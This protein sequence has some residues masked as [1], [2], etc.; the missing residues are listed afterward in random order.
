MRGRLK[1]LGRDIERKLDDHEV[2]KLLTTI[3]GVGITAA[4]L[5]AELGDPTRFRSAGAIASYVGV[6]SRLRQSGRKRFSPGALQSGWVTL[7]CGRLSGWWFSTPCDAIRGCV[8]ITNAFGSAGKPGRVAII[9]AMRKLLVAV[10]SVATHR[11]P[12]SRRVT[13]KHSKAPARGP[14]CASR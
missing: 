7:A 2:G 8:S 5:I 6:A 10:W 12:Q 9:A 11:R 3:D 14:Y 4:C 13:T 1:D